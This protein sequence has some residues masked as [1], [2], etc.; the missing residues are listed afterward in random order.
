LFEHDLFGKPVSTFPDH[1]LAE[2]MAAAGLTHGGFYRHFKTKSQLVAEVCTAAMQS[3][4]ATTTKAPHHKLCAADIEDYLSVEHCE[5]TMNGCIIAALA[6]ELARANAEVREAVSS[7]LQ[8]TSDIFS[9]KIRPVRRK[10]ARSD[11]LFIVAAMMGAVTMA[12]IVAHPA[13]S[14]AI[15]RSARKHLRKIG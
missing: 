11:A 9:Q 8:E 12:R 14:A 2:V 10:L 3:A 7:R 1:A 4:V 6:S 15:L 5:D 13:K